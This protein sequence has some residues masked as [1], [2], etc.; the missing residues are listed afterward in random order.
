MV[1]F[2]RGKERGSSVIES[3]QN[4]TD[5][6]GFA[7]V[8]LFELLNPMHDRKLDAQERAVKSLTHQLRLLPFD[9]DAAVE[10]AN[11]MGLLKRLGQQVNALDVMI[12]GTAVANGAEK[13]VSLDSDF[14][15]IGRVS[16]VKI[17]IVH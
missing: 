17:E 5:S 4:I 2:L 16:E 11:I 13:I 3:Q 10:S 12:A 6:I 8:S 1:D 14:L 9:S 15:R 7:T